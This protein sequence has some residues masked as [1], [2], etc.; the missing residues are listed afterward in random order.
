MKKVIKSEICKERPNAVALGAF[1]SAVKIN[2]AFN[3]A[4]SIRQQIAQDPDNV[5]KRNVGNAIIKR[6]D[7]RKKRI[8]KEKAKKLKDTNKY[9]KSI[10]VREIDETEAI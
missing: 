5:Y 9:R 3:D 8:L 7:A 1:N 4:D 6:I 2:S 10:G